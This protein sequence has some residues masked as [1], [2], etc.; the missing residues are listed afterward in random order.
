MISAN[1]INPHLTSPFG[2]GEGSIVHFLKIALSI[3]SFYQNDQICQS[4]VIRSEKHRATEKCS[5][6]IVIIR[7]GKECG[8]PGS[9]F[10]YFWVQRV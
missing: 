5:E 3:G 9:F 7:E 6:D 2:K 4:R 10:F 1:P 8:F